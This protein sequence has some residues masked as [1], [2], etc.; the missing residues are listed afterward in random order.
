MLVYSHKI[1]RGQNPKG[2]KTMKSYNYLITLKGR[3]IAKSSTLENAQKRYNE[4][5]KYLSVQAA[6]NLPNPYLK[7]GEAFN[8]QDLEIKKGGAQ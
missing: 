7:R 2:L 5:L 4:L 3:V 8:S 1:T 6:K